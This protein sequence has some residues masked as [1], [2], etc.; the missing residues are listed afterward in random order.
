MA[1]AEQ[2]ID[3]NQGYAEAVLGSAESALQ[4]ASNA[5]TGVGYAQPVVELEPLESPPDVPEPGTPPALQGAEF[6]L[7]TAPGDAPEY[8][9]VGTLDVSGAPSQTAQAPVI[10]L[11]ARPTEMAAFTGQLPTIHTDVQFPEP[12]DQLENP[13]F[14]EPVIAERAVPVKPNVMLP[15]FDNAAPIWDGQAPPD[16]S[17]EMERAYRSMGPTMVAALDGQVD[18]MLAKYCPRYHSSL[19]TLELKLSMFIDG[20][21]ALAPDVERALIERGRDRDQGEYRRVRESA[22]EE[23]AKR[24]FTLPSGA[25]MSAI[26]KAR[27]SAGDNFSRASVEVVVKQAELEQQNTQ[28]ALTQSLNLRQSILSAMLGFHG[29]LI[30]I[31]AQALD[32]AKAV[33]NLLVETFNVKARAFQAQVEAWRAEAAVYE[34]RL[35]GALALIDLYKAEIDALQALTQVDVARVN[36]YR[37]RIDSLQALANVYRTRVDAIVSKAQLEKLKIDLF[38]AQVQAFTAQTNAKANEWN[39][40]KAAIDGEDSKVRLFSAQVQADGQAVTI[41][42]AKVEA[43]AQAADA[44]ARTN[45]SRARQYEAAWN[46]YRSVVGARGDVARTKLENERQELIAFQTVENAK[47]GRAQSAAA[48][49][50]ARADVQI[51]YA[52]VTLRSQ[53]GMIDSMR[54][55][56][57]VIA[58]LANTNADIHGKMAG[59]AMGGINSIAIKE[60]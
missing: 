2:I 59:M 40:F 35:K 48:I 27:Q 37:A 25:L 9:D 6:T 55:Y 56:Q 38:G 54:G 22:W 47:L 51:G 49:Y 1:S 19:E 43:Q 18:A 45:D 13:L 11:P 32:F 41:W 50:K 15:V 26:G 20:G 17:G 39:G 3:A 53:L 57:T 60:E 28:F 44:A 33:A 46:A 4:A 7:P 23:A 14:P 10:Q 24:G 52:E 58:Q 21:T 31:N 12:P 29:N 36:V 34:T 8:Q 42:K 30:Q 5:I 16:L